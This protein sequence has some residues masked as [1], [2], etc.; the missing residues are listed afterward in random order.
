[1]QPGFY[2]DL[3]ALAR[4]G[5]AKVALKV[6]GDLFLEGIESV[7]HLVFPNLKGASS[8]KDRNLVSRNRR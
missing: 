4:E 3:I 7:P 6:F 1:M 5:G 2:K 8:L